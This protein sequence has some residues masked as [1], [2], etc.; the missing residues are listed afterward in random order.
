MLMIDKFNEVNAFGDN[1]EL[2]DVIGLLYAHRIYISDA[3]DEELAED[4]LRAIEIFLETDEEYDG[5]E[6]EAWRRL[7]NTH[8]EELLKE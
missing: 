6:E 7:L 1:K 5:D 4:V 8:I 2:E 3:L